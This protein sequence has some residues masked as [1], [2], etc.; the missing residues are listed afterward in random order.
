MLLDG[1]RHLYRKAI[2]L[3]VKLKSVPSFGDASDF[4][5]IIDVTEFVQSQWAA[6]KA[7][8]WESL[9]TP[10]E[11]V[12]TVSDPQIAQHIGVDSMGK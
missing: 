8:N 2:Q 5:C 3:G 10:Q 7:K 11:R 12:Y 1:S 9:V 6:V 4:I